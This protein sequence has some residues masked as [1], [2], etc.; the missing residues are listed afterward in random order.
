MPGA[1][2]YC[3]GDVEAGQPTAYGLCAVCFGLL[4]AELTVAAEHVARPG[5]PGA[6][7]VADE[8]LPD[9]MAMTTPPSPVAHDPP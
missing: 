1:C 8:L 3:G 7:T 6:E 2:A 5:T 9:R 4:E